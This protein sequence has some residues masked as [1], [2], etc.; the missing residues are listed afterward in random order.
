MYQEDFIHL[1]CELFLPKI[2]WEATCKI[3]LSH[4]ELLWFAFRET[5]YNININIAAGC[6]DQRAKKETVNCQN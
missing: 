6:I 2:I 3:K 4:I 5:P 1:L